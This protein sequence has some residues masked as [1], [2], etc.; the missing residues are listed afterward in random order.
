MN[1]SSDDYIVMNNTQNDWVKLNVGGTIIHTTLS[2][3]RKERDS[4]LELMF[5]KDSTWKHHRDDNGCILIDADPRYFLIILNFLRHGEI[6]VEP[7]LNYYGVIALARYF[8]LHSITDM[9]D[10]EESNSNAWVNLLEENFLTNELDIGKWTTSKECTGSNF[11]IDEGFIKLVNRAYFSTKEQY[12]PED[13]E[14]RISGIWI[15]QSPED[16]FQIVT[17]SDGKSQGAPYFEVNNGLEFHYSR[18]AA[19]IIGRGGIVPTGIVKIKK[20]GEF[21]FGPLVPV[22]FEIYDDGCTVSFSLRDTINKTSIEV[23]TTCTNKSIQNYIVIH[24]REKTGASHISTLTNIKIQR[25]TK[26]T[27]RRNRYK[28]ISS[29]K[30][31]LNTSI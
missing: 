13:G 4:M 5:K 23:E 25:W 12:N 7:N 20:Q 27:L 22:Y 26:S 14:I 3:L 29:K 15:K 6:I 19:N 28:R 16:F 11:S 17:R 10:N 31:N 1:R 21:F 8:Q 30:V 18:G 9:I 2:T 24:N